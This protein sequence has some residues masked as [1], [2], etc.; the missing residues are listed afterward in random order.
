MQKKEILFEK[1]TTVYLLFEEPC[2]ILYRAELC[3]G[4]RLCKYVSLKTKGI[5]HSLK[6]CH[7]I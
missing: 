2:Y 6:L 4:N 5:S 3:K 7:T 1:C